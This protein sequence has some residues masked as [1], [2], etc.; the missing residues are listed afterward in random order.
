M[1][2][3]VYM[4]VHVYVCTCVCVI[5]C[6]YLCLCDYMVVPVSVWLY[7]YTCVCVTVCLYLCLCDCV[8]T[9]VCVTVCLYLCLCDC[10]SV[11]VSVW[12]TVS[13]PVSVWLYVYTCV[14]VSVCVHVYVYMQEAKAHYETLSEDYREEVAKL[15]KLVDSAVDAVEFV[16]ASGNW[17]VSVSTYN[18]LICIFISLSDYPSIQV[19]IDSSTTK[20]NYQYTYTCNYM[21]SLYVLY[22]IIYFDP[23]INFIYWYMYSIH[24]CQ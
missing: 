14:C 8:C 13:V 24:V 5:G 11:P 23:S 22:S 10:M 19:F 16:S 2:L 18:V 20:L 9:C 17:I 15:Q 6:L 3:S 12:R 21:Y 1:H 4:H 7:V